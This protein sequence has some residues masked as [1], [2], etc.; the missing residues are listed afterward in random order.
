[1]V[2]GKGD[3]NSAEFQ[4]AVELLYGL[5]FT[6]KMSKKKEQEPRGYFDYVILPLEGLWWISQGGFSFTQRENWLWTVMIR[7]PEFVDGEV[8]K[9]AQEALVRKKPELAVGKAGFQTFHEGLCVQCLH[10]GPYATEPETMAKLE[11]FMRAEGWRDLVGAGGKH[12]E[13]Y[14]SDPRKAKPESMKTVLR[15]PV[16]RYE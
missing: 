9:W 11:A 7:Q 10:S 6:I 4:Q 15:H 14:L 8:F 16:K 12:H 13:I 3:P 5:S 1:M 2:D